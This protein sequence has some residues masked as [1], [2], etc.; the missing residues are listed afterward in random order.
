MISRT[1][2]NNDVLLIGLDASAESPEGKEVYTAVITS[3]DIVVKYQL[4]ETSSKMNLTKSI[5]PELT[6][7]TNPPL[8]C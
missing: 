4:Q 5:S 6:S 7:A 2:G 3:V 8:F 1:E